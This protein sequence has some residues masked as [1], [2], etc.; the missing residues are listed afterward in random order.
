MCCPWAPGYSGSNRPYH[1]LP[2][3]NRSQLLMALSWWK[4][5][6]LPRLVFSELANRNR[7]WKNEFRRWNVRE[8]A[9]I[10]EWREEGRI[11]ASIATKRA[12]LLE[13]FSL[14]FGQAPPAAMA[15]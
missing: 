7:L 3:P 2:R 4:A 8:S 1:P 15:S 10:N 6:I 9:I 13:L 5:R 12:D 14:R 11:E